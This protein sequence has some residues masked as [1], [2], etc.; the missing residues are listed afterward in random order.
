LL[1]NDYY[2]LLIAIKSI[3]VGRFKFGIYV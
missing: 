2:C 3:N 1:V